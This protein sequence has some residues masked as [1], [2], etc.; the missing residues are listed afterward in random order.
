LRIIAEFD[1]YKK[2]V[3]IDRKELFFMA[4]KELFISV[5]PVLDA[6]DRGLPEI[7]K[8][9]GMMLIQ[10]KLLKIFKQK[11]LKKIDLKKGDNFNTDFHEAIT[12]ISVTNEELKS[13]IID[14]LESGYILEDKV[15]RHAKVVIGK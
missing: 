12:H 11:G 9:K 2:R 5:L 6:F 15:I 14:V 3:Q 13:K 7:I 1:N 8:S 10:E 4:K